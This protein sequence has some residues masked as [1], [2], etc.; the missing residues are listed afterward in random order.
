MVS[1]HCY[2]GKDSFSLPWRAK[3]LLL[4]YLRDGERRQKDAEEQPLAQRAHSLHK[5]LGYQILECG[6]QPDGN[7][8]PLTIPPGMQIKFTLT[9]FPEL[10]GQWA[11][12]SILPGVCAAEIVE[13]LTQGIFW[14]KNNSKDLIKDY[15][16]KAKGISQPICK[17]HIGNEWVL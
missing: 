5:W 7:A 4:F 9:D 17:P 10:L 1:N 15:L 11:Q 8:C 3:L 6:N 14:E 12:A 13:R 16:K 2:L